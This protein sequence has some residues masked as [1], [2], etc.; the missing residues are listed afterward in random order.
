MLLGP[1]LCRLRL[2]VGGARPAPS[3]RL[4]MGLIGLGSMGMRHVKGFLQEKDCRIVAV[5]DV[6]A[7]RRRGA[8]EEV[9]KHYGN[10]DCTQ[11]NDFREL[12]GLNDIDTLCISVPDH[13]HSIIALQGIRAGKGIFPKDGLWDAAVDYDFE[14][15]YADGL[16][17]RVA[18]NN[19][20][21]Q[22][23]RFIGENA[24]IHITREGLDANPKR[25]LKEKTG[26][27]EIHLAKPAGDHRRGHRRDFLDCVKTRAQTITPVAI[28]HRS[29]IPCHL[30]NIS[31]ILGRSIRWDA[32]REVIVGDTTANRMLARAM[33]SPWH[34]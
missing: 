7:G 10:G 5:C 4:T 22:G 27:D 21:R 9:N 33:C 11:Y 14:C 15:K 28:G 19:H 32:E 1:I 18:S 23:V 25:L 26:P 20:L 16:I 8:V 6:D 34:L 24:W 29:A 13:W 31:M 2:L 12:I 3:S 30:G 17:M